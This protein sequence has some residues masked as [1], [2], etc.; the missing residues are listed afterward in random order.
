VKFIEQHPRSP[1][2]INAFY[3]LFVK[4]GPRQMSNEELDF[5]FEFIDRSTELWGERMQQSLRMSAIIQITSFYSY[6]E[7]MSQQLARVEG[8]PGD[9]I[10]EEVLNRMKEGVQDRIDLAL[11]IEQ[12]PNLEPE[13]RAARLQELPEELETYRFD[14]F[15][16]AKVGDVL[17]A[18]QY[19]ELAVQYYAKLI[20]IPGLESQYLRVIGSYREKLGSVS[21]RLESAWKRL[22]ND[23]LSGL[24]E[25]KLQA[26]EQFIEDF[27]V[28][29][30]GISFDSESPNLLIE[31]FTG[32]S[33]PPC[34]AADMSCAIL[35]R[36]LSPEHFTVLQY[37]LHSPG[38]DPLTNADSEA[39]FFSYSGSG[40]PAA[41]LNGRAL[42]SLGGP[43]SSIPAN[44]MSLM[45]ELRKELSLK[46]PLRIELTG[47]RSGKNRISCSANVAADSLSARW[48]LIVVLAE[49]KIHFTGENGVPIHEMVVRKV[50]T[51][52][53]GAEPQDEQLAW[54][55]MIDLDNLRTELNEFL[56]HDEQKYSY[57]FPEKPLDLKELHL[58]AFVQDQQNRRIRQ[59]QSIPVPS[60]TDSTDSGDN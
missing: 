31:L 18:A 8:I 33:C 41:F 16:L 29:L 58:V 13:E 47:N 6:P 44:V 2:V 50:L 37:H 9:S 30:S 32:S 57:Q 36:K 34:I 7:F 38:P 35:S 39:R 24:S 26:Y 46:P 12:I 15:L 5:L 14:P 23:D 59:V 54:S 56:S 20:T 4:C 28:D 25:F 3:G 51:P 43:P 53:L 48:R 55:G 1:Y 42:N 27:E 49:D 22:H 45:T 10:W 40:T 52:P 11:R 19:D 60:V 17:T 21:D